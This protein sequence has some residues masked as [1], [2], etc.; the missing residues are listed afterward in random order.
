MIFLWPIA[1]WAYIRVI[2]AERLSNIVDKRPIVGAFFEPIENHVLNAFLDEFRD[3]RKALISHQLISETFNVNIG[4]VF[5]ILYLLEA[6]F[7]DFILPIIA[8][9]SLFQLFLDLP[10]KIWFS[11]LLFEFLAEICHLSVFVHLVFLY[12]FY[13][14]LDY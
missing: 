9:Q 8:S 5:L 11:K 4:K 7:F 2:L 6:Q 3:F 1:F 12:L 13:Y 10:L 14:I